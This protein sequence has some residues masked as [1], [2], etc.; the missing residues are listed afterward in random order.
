MNNDWRRLTT[1]GWLAALAPATLLVLAPAAAA[2][3]YCNLT[4]VEVSPLTNGVQLAFVADGV[5]EWRPENNDWNAFFGENHQKVSEIAIR[6][7]GARSKLDSNFVD[8]GRI[9]V[10]HVQVAV[11]QDAQRGIGLAAKII[12]SE[13]A[14]FQTAT[15]PDQQRLMITVNSERTLETTPTGTGTTTGVANE[16]KLV[17]EAL[18]GGIAVTALKADIHEVFAQVGAKAG[19]SI[20]VDDAVQHKASMRL[21]AM[22]PLVVLQAIASAYGLAVSNRS[23]MYMISEGVPKDMATYN[24]SG[25]ESF[26]LKH[27]TAAEAQGLLPTFLFSYLHVNKEQN[28]LVVTAPTQML[29][30]IHR[31]LEQ[32]DV[33]PPLIMVE[34]LAVELTNTQDAN[35]GVNWSYR[36]HTSEVSSDTQ[37]GDIRF[38]DLGPQDFDSGVAFTRTLAAKLD[39][40]V[41][42]GRAEIRASPRMAAVNGEKAEIFIGAQRFIKVQY[43]QY[44][45][46]QERIQG[47]PVGVRLAV[48]PWT[49]SNSEITT[50]AT[51]EVSNIIEVDSQ[52]GLPLLSTRRAESTVRTRADETIVIG[53]LSQRQE[54][55]TVRKVPILGDLPLIGPLLFRRK[56]RKAVD[57]E[58]VIFLTPRILT[59]TGRLPNQDEEAAMRRR[60]LEPGDPGYPTE[61]PP[62]GPPAPA[63]APQ[64]P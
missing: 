30:K 16:G 59:P 17:V 1:A 8:V 51:V 54:E 33:A 11:P 26:A 32:V 5:L 25:T 12:M 38:H 52:T 60:F 9:P 19:L 28:A 7:P 24:R 14:T 45:Q 57:S 29:E 15:S 48:Q 23:G 43:L 46:Q 56:L 40:L 3:V 39:T 53:G 36:G 2:Q 37:T 27:M 31:D 63:A 50:H 35:L 4:K 22:D 41:A 49:G 42:A 61:A 13:P 21:P 6:F 55:Q 44:G 58:L 20:A 18:D 47:V 64:A 62:T 34:A 10:S